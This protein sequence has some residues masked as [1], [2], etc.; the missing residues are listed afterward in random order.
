VNTTLKLGRQECPIAI[1][2]DWPVVV[3]EPRLLPGS[4]SPSDAIRT[5]LTN[6]D[7]TLP[8][9][10]LV[11]RGERV[12]L[13][14]NDIT[15]RAGT[16]LLLPVL[17]E[18]LNRAGI[19]DADIFIVFALGLHRAHTREE[20]ELIVGPEIASRINLIDHDSRDPARLL[21]LGTT[22]R[23]NR[24]LINREVCEADRVIITGEIIH[25]L[26]AG[27]SGGR[28]SI[29]PG[30]AG[31]ETITFNHSMI[32]DPNCR[33]GLLAGNPAHEDMVEACRLL[34]PDFMV[35]LVLNFK[36]EVVHVAAGDWEK[37]HL[38]GCQIV[39]HMFRVDSEEAFDLVIAS[40]GGFPYD[41]NLYQAQK[42]L[43]NAFRILRPGGC[44]VYLAECSNGSGN[45]AFEEWM[46]RYGSAA[47]IEK[48]LK[49]QFVIG[50]HKAYWVSRLAE[51]GTTI[52][53]SGFD[54]DQ[55]RRFR[56]L[57]A[58]DATEALALAAAR[59]G[60]EPKT[61]LLPW[62]ALTLPTLASP[63]AAAA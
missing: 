39:D 44:V 45:R 32:F 16:E 1:P 61:A 20:Q 5:A 47:E 14:V 58:R 38:E 46:S 17:L 8:L 7:G 27:F 40:A 15:R 4:A 28:K 42:G 24:V 19:P 62:A 12:C 52:L 6:P 25:H 31:A 33:A 41:I 51:K 37:A 35:N 53:V 22:S 11:Q 50:G 56:M 54:P 60:P 2:D 26:I 63:R 57:P 23:G 9:H 55:V 3:L 13:V 18:E 29:M 10:E 59:L 21:D 48:Q 30:V 34:D 36:G 43:E 49:K